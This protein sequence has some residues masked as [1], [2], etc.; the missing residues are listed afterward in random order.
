MIHDLLTFKENLIRF[1]LLFPRMEGSL[2]ALGLCI[3]AHILCFWNEL[4]QALS[5]ELQGRD[6]LVALLNDVSNGYNNFW[7]YQLNKATP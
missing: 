4:L 1:Q 3:F 2:K 7:S 5:T 6:F